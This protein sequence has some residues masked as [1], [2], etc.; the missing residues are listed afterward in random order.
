MASAA[1]RTKVK[2]KKGQKFSSITHWQRRSRHQF[3]HKKREFEIL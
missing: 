3:C 2:G 1:D